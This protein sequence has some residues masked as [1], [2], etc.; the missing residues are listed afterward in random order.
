MT[1][2]ESFDAPD[3][4]IILRTL[5]H[6]KC[7]FRVH[8][9]VLSLAS[10]VFK[11]MFSLP[12]PTSDDSRRSSSVVGIGIIEVA[13]PAEALDIVLRMIYPFTPPS[14]E[15]NLDTLVECLVVADK[16]DLRG[17][18]SQLYNA[19]ARFNSTH[20]L[21][22][23]AIAVRF[24]FAGLVDSTFRHIIS[25]VHLEAIP[26]LPD[27][28]DFIPASAYHKLVRHRANYLEEVV[29]A[30]KKTGFQ[31]WCY[32]CRWGGHS[33]TEV[34]RLRLAHLIMTGTPVGAGAC[35]EAW[36]KAYGKNAECEGDCVLKFIYSALPR[37][38]KGLVKP[39]APPVQK[40]VA[41]RKKPAAQ[42]DFW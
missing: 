34:F 30:I 8:K 39:G 4:D 26:E 14:F 19:L 7:D 23:Y 31:S 41:P 5:G 18:K 17:A 20:S 32:D 35:A 1:N 11:D 21:R 15:G 13:D 29:E 2:D 12:E 37:V 16:Y 27:D 28:F 10:P 40:K 22:V 38:D 24:G 3:A 36:M 25:S 6:P 9:L 42:C 33:T